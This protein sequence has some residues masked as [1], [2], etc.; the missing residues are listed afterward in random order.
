V[1]NINPANTHELISASNYGTGNFLLLK[2][3]AGNSKTSIANSG[4]ITTEGTVTVKG[5]KGIVR[6]SNTAQLRI[7]TVIAEIN[8]ND[9]ITSME[10]KTVNVTFSTPFSSPP[11]VY[12]GNNV[13]E[14]NPGE[15][16][17]AARFMTLSVSD[18][19]ANGCKLRII[20]GTATTKWLASTTSWNLVAIGAE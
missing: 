10:T 4:N 19:T 2:D 5:T 1:E 11:V 12:I 20:N 16:V 15:E 8:V 18:V 14:P 17:S 7:E 6:N 9:W 3:G 13:H